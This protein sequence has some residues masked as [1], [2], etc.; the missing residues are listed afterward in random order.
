MT[1]QRQ[2]GILLLNWNN[3]ENILTHIIEM[4]HWKTP[5]SII[6]VDNASKT[7]ISIIVDK[8]FPDVT[9][10]KSP[11]NRGF[12]GG[13]N[14][15]FHVFIKEGFEYILL[16][17]HDADISEETVYNLLEV[18]RNDSR[19]GVIG[20]CIQ[21]ETKRYAG[22]RNIAHYPATR[23]PYDPSGALLRKVDYL[24]GT[25]CILRVATLKKV[26]TFDERYFFSGEMADL[27]L[28]IRNSGHFCIVHTG[29]EIIHN[30]GQDTPMRERIHL[31]YSVRNRFLYI[32]KHETKYIIWIIFWIFFTCSLVISA[33]FKG[34]THSA[35]AALLGARDGIFQRY[36]DRNGYFY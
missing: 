19:I 13:N 26:G 8:T 6:I 4:T 16:L 5:P 17:N 24:P 3:E 2:L 28:R 23:I 11:V 34:K 18:M 35:K 15:G 7:D 30:V 32:R 22:G 21:E 27:C 29:V 9:I 14:L 25:A 31:Y 1:L 12:S 33:M 36:G 20:P 10:I